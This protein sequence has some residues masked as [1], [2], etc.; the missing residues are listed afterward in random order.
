MN[1]LSALLVA[2]G[3]SMDNWAVT[4][5]SGCSHRNAISQT[6]IF[7]VSAL[8]SL[9]HFVMFSGGWLCGAGL[10]R[11]IG[12][13]DHWIAFF[14]LVFIGARMI[15]ESRG[16]KEGSDVCLLHSFKTLLA[17]AVATGR[18]AGGNG[19]GV[20]RRSVLDNGVDADGVRVRY[21]LDGFL[22]RRLFRPKVW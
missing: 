9:A 16:A 20:Y 21:Q 12:A 19:A 15:K 10:G 22:S 8:F 2:L 6:Y 17:L 3:L 13:V 11:Y 14:I 7:K 1:I 5:A 18:A 4:I